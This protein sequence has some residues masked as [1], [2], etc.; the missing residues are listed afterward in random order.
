VQVSTTPSI[1]Q[2][3]SAE[4]VP[5]GVLVGYADS[6]L[7]PVDSSW[8]LRTVA[9]GDGALGPEQTVF[10][11]NASQIGWS[12]ISTASH[13][14]SMLA[15]ASDEADGMYAVPIDD[16][17]ATA[18]ARVTTSGNQGQFLAA[19]GSGFS[20][21]RSPW[22]DTGEIPPPV[23]LA[24]LSTAG[25]VTSETTILGADPTITDFGR[26]V[27][28]DQS[29]LLWWFASGA[30]GG[31]SFLGRAFDAMGGALGGT[32][33]LRA[34]SATDFGGLVLAASTTSPS[35]VLGVWPS[36]TMTGAALLA[37]PFDATGATVGAPVAWG[38]QD[39]GEFP[40]MA[41]TGAPGGDFVV[42]WLDQSET[43]GGVLQVQAVASDGTSEGPPTMLGDIAASPETYVLLVATTDG[44]M[45]FYE[46]DTPEYVEVFAI[47]LRCAE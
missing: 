18:G 25:D 27:R 28:E 4:P 43:S 10:T 42:A 16:T 40:T 14:A 6:Q 46:S 24:T 29:F 35:V 22:D 12:A 11:R 44:A 45:V 1:V 38:T 5:G 8:H 33:T 19:A 20:V 26:V 15:V 13:G 34:V 32:V 9:Y 47:P 31:G 7:P 23:S 17:G 30:S 36:A 39:G 41:V 3:L 37:Q 2:V 21:L